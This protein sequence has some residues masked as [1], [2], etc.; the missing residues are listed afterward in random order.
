MACHPGGLSRL[1]R[2][3]KRRSRLRVTRRAKI[4][5]NKTATM[6]IVTTVRTARRKGREARGRRRRTRSKRNSLAMAVPQSE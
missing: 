1:K 5:R 6:L 2:G 3:K 4:V